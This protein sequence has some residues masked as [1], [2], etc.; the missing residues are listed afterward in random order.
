MLFM[1]IY[2]FLNIR[3]EGTNESRLPS[4]EVPSN[5]EDIYL[6]YYDTLFINTSVRGV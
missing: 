5:N 6:R 3:N 2:I 4:I 1:K